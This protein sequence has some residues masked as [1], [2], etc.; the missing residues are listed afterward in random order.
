MQKRCKRSRA[1]TGMGNSVLSAPRAQACPALLPLR[2]LWSLLLSQ[3]LTAES[4]LRLW[5]LARTTPAAGCILSLWPGSMPSKPLPLHL[6][7]GVGTR[8]TRVTISEEKP[9]SSR[10]LSRIVYDRALPP[11]PHWLPDALVPSVWAALDT[12]VRSS[13][14]GST[15]EQPGWRTRITSRME[16]KVILWDFSDLAWVCPSRLLSLRLHFSPLVPA[17]KLHPAQPVLF[18]ASVPLYLQWLLEKRTSVNTWGVCSSPRRLPHLLSEAS[19]LPFHS[20]SYLVLW[21]LRADCICLPVLGPLHS[22]PL[23]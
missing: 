18:H 14:P 21:V 12:G 15:N 8:Q 17:L 11:W 10:W 22:S 3:F 19:L 5:S 20:L 1:A 4:E 7:T 6:D 9:K 16:F 23:F 2:Q 13:S